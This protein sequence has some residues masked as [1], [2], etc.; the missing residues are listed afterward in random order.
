MKAEVHGVGPAIWTYRRL[1]EDF[2]K[3]TTFVNIALHEKSI[4]WYEKL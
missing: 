1:R 3:L 4:I 2:K